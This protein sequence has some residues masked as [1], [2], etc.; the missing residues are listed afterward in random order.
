MLLTGKEV[1]QSNT[2]VSGVDSSIENLHLWGEC[3]MKNTKLLGDKDITRAYHTHP[4]MI[5]EQC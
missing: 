3:T 5:P 1:A 2:V 4:F